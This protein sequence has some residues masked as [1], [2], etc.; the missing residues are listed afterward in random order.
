[1]IIPVLECSELRK[2]NLM[3]GRWAASAAKAASAY[4]PI[5]W[6]SLVA[7]IVF[8]TAHMTIVLHVAFGEILADIIVVL[9]VP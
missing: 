7:V 8:L 4:V 9:D 5:A 1:M 2:Q 6:A 3:R